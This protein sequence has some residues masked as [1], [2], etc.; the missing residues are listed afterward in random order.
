V[1]TTVEAALRSY[2]L[3]QAAVT[4]LVADRVFPG[5]F[6]QPAAYP[7]ILVTRVASSR[8]VTHAG[9][10]TLARVR[11]QLD[12]WALTYAGAH[13]LAEAVRKCLNGFRGSF[14]GSPATEVPGAFLLTEY[15]VVE[16]DAN[17]HRLTQDW[18]VW[19]QEEAPRWQP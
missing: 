13:D 4:T 8:L 12:L 3:Q 15:D 18:Q 17:A 11:L 2:L 7:A 16:P 6:E 10:S 5:R 1:S 19:E 9:V 14:P